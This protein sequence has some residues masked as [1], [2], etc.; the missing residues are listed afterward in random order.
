MVQ[1]L[2][3]GIIRVAKSDRDNRSFHRLATNARDT[4]GLSLVSRGAAEE[5]CIGPP[6]RCVA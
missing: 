3:A 1:F 4:A 5:F 6:S 2:Q